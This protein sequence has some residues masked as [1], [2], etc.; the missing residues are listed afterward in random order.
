[1]TKFDTRESLPSVFGDRLGI[2]PVTRGTYVI[3]DFDLY[4]DFPE[5]EGQEIWSRG[6]VCPV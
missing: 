6:P 4:A 2:L 1:M 5:Q 3:G